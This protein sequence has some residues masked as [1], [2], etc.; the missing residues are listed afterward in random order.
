MKKMLY[1]AS[2]GI[3]ILGIPLFVFSIINTEVSLKYETKH[4]NECISL[5]TGQNL[6]LT[7]KVMQGLI[8]L[9]ILIITTLLVFK[10][11]ILKRK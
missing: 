7:I 5:V 6:C 3:S 1:L 4:P 10:K 2:L 8:V 9:C 11:N